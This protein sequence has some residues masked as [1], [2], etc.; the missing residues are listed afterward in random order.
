[1]GSGGAEE[2]G[3]VDDAV[4]LAPG[5]LGQAV[6]VVLVRQ[7]LHLLTW[8]T[9]GQLL[10]GQVLLLVKCWSTAAVVNCWSTAAG[11][12]LL[13]YKG[14]CTTA[15]PPA[16]PAQQTGQILHWSNDKL[17]GNVRQ[18]N[19]QPWAFCLS[20]QGWSKWSKVDKGGRSG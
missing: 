17:H 2:V 4:G 9:A 13:S 12:L 8:S 10:S 14:V 18:S 11:Q 1:M 5:G 3:D 15:A 7:Q 6:G 20:G 19:G 16:M